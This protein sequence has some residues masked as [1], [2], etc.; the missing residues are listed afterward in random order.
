MKK[1][2][3]VFFFNI[4][5][6]IPNTEPSIPDQ[7]SPYMCAANTLAMNTRLCIDITE[8]PGYM[9]KD[10]LA[11]AAESDG[12]QSAEFRERIPDFSKWEAVFEK[13]DAKAIEEKFF[14]TD[15]F[16][17]M[18]IVGIS[19]QQAEDF[20]VWRTKMFEAELAKM[21][22]RERAQFPK[23]FRFRLPTA[24]EWSRMRFLAL[25]KAML[26]RLDKI[27]NGNL[28]AFKFSKSKIMQN[29][30]KVSHIY[31]SKDSK[32]GFFNLFD[33]VAEMTSE[34]GI[35]VGGSWYGPNEKANYQQTF[36][37]TS[38]EA[39]LGLRCIFE[40]ID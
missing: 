21:S 33:N 23:K 29:N 11:T 16:A 10:Y 5:W 6:A 34:E 3:L 32:V 25:E 17:L 22:K 15:E 1:L 20:C 19:R 7:D 35:A 24:S 13:L 40:I 9:Y 12:E 31:E 8:V 28:K 18:P 36:E 4:A 38:P 39:W 27:A 14:E 2:A 37:Y 30:E 26:K